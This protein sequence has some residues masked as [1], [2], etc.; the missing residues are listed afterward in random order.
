MGVDHPAETRGQGINLTA[1]CADPTPQYVSSVLI[2][3][4]LEACADVNALVKLIAKPD[5]RAVESGISGYCERQRAQARAL[6]ASPASR[7]PI[8]KNSHGYLHR[9]GKAQLVQATA[10]IDTKI[11][12]K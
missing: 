12:T 5:I 9:P 4:P 2:G 6:S 10:S 1:S 3:K 11:L 7:S 8:S